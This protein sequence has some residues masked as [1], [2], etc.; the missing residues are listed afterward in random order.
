M[1]KK[2]SGIL[3]MLFLVS[4]AA[5]LLLELSSGSRE[6][7]LLGDY[8]TSE[9]VAELSRA[10]G[11]S[12][13]FLSRYLLFLY[14]FLTLQWGE[15]IKGNSILSLVSS[16]L[17]MTLELSFLSI[18]LSVALSL[19]VAIFSKR[20][21]Q[22]FFD[23]LTDALS[24]LIFSLP[25]FVL[26]LVLV[27]LLPMFPTGGFVPISRGLGRN[28]L[29]MVLPVLSSTLMHYAILVRVLKRSLARE[30]EKP[31]ARS[32]LARGG[33]EEDQVLVVLRSASIPYLALIS[34]SFCSMLAGSCIIESVFS[35]P[36]LGSLFVS[37]ALSRD[38]WLA[39]IL[40][41]LFFILV[42]VSSIISEAV[43]R[44]LDPRIRRSIDE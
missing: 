43:M 17:S 11:S 16:R 36:G 25:S 5:F 3:L 14:S 42:S 13:T 2:V 24:I 9:S 37:A 1:V 22:S 12:G 40:V 4:L 27:L 39:T 28:L 26:S 23:K 8:A 38:S 6:L 15:D 20:R 7:Y 31:Y 29:H 21:R 44:T 34:E 18:F 35:L 33:R 32:A 19:V 10:L 30:L 41:L